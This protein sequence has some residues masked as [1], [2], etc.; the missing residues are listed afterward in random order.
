MDVFICHASEDY[1]VAQSLCHLLHF[2]GINYWIAEQY[3]FGGQSYIQ[4]IT[5]G[6]V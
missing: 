2:N 1:E 3:E 4:G 5:D 6:S